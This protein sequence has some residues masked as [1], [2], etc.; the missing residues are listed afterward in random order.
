MRHEE[1]IYN[2]YAKNTHAKAQ[3]AIDHAREVR[4]KKIAERGKPGDR[5]RCR[6]SS[7]FF[8]R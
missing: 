5:V 3:D 2:P 7:V 8:F 4:E 6:K 1:P